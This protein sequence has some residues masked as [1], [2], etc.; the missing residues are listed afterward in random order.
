MKDLKSANVHCTISAIADESC[1]KVLEIGDIFD[2][3][4]MEK[5]PQTVDKFGEN[6]EFHTYVSFE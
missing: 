5:L 3:T 4:L 6:G 2:E 1:K